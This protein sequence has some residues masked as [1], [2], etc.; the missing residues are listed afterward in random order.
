MRRM[1]TRHARASCTLWLNSSEST[2]QCQYCRPEPIPP[3][4]FRVLPDICERFECSAWLTRW[5]VNGEKPPG[6]EKAK[7]EK[8]A[9]ATEERMGMLT[10][11][12][13]AAIPLIAM[14]ALVFRRSRGK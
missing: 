4:C 13:V 14:A 5:V 7:A 11:G 3:F 2:C 6:A 1:V 8:D 9:K 12:L 10:G